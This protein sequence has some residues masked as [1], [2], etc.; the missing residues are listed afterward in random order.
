M[1]VLFGPVFKIWNVK[2]HNNSKD[3][4]ICLTSSRLKY[5]A[6]LFSYQFVPEKTE[7]SS[8]EVY[9]KLSLLA[10]DLSTYLVKSEHAD[11][12]IRLL[13]DV[14]N[15][16]LSVC[17]KEDLVNVIHNIILVVNSLSSTFSVASGYLYKDLIFDK[18]SILKNITRVLDC[19]PFT[20][21]KSNVLLSE[22]PDIATKPMTEII[23]YSDIFEINPME[24]STQL[25]ERN[26]STAS[27]HTIQS[28]LSLFHTIGSI[29]DRPM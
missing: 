13:L 15:L 10:S 27:F 19:F 16:C 7:C 9:K 24:L 17:I 5:F 4:N 22:I 8:L 1:I 20:Q 21:S 14:L 12:T 26:T 29:N 23:K 2:N 3:I 28:I 11:G 25:H 18:N 6:D